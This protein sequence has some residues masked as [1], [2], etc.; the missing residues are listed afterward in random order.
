M[1]FPWICQSLNSNYSELIEKCMK[2]PTEYMSIELESKLISEAV[3]IAKIAKENK[4]QIY[5]I[6]T[7]N[8]QGST[9]TLIKDTTSRIGGKK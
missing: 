6:P 3:K 1:Q 8:S 5:D 4:K 2:S 9:V 7:K